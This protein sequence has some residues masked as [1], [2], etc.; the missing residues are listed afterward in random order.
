[1]RA[2]AQ[3]EG[4]VSGMMAGFECRQLWGEG[5]GAGEGHDQVVCMSSLCS[6]TVS[7]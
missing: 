1:M 3:E 4:Q 7:R 2:V 5:E 6:T